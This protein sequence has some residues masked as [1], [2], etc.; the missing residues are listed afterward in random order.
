MTME[1]WSVEHK[2]VEQIIDA[3][4]SREENLMVLGQT[5]LE[6]RCY[7]EYFLALQAPKSNTNTE[8]WVQYIIGVI[9]IP[10]LIK[11][12]NL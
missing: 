1:L 11:N 7:F 5:I 2:W 8:Y 4:W 6:L 3:S 10:K 12:L 9:L